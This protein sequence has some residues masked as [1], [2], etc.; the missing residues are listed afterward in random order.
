MFREWE[1]RPYGDQ[2]LYI[3]TNIWMYVPEFSFW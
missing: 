1:N 2:T 3:V